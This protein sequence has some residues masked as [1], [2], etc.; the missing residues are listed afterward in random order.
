MTFQIINNT[1]IFLSSCRRMLNSWLLLIISRELCCEYAVFCL[2][3]LVYK[4]LQMWRQNDVIGR[5]EYLIFTCSESTVPYKYIHCNICLNIHITH[6]DMEQNVSGCFF[7]NTVYSS[8]SCFVRNGGDRRPFSGHSSSRSVAKWCV[9]HY[10]LSSSP[11][12]VM[13][14]LGVDRAMP[15]KQSMNASI[16]NSSSS[17]FCHRKT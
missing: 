16:V 2:E 12:Y 3:V 7:L 13:R 10:E 5:N 15:C 14:D 8:A 17:Y 11:V 1:L 9:S 6:G 4:R